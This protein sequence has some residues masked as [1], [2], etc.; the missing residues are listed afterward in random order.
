VAE[1]SVLREFLVEL[2]FRIDEHGMRKFLGETLRVSKGV[3]EIGAA[4]VATAGTVVEMTKKIAERFQSLYFATKFTGASASNIEQLGYALSNVGISSDEAQNS[5]IGLMRRLRDVVGMEGQLNRWGVATRDAMGR[6][7]DNADILVDLIARIRK[8]PFAARRTQMAEMAGIDPDMITKLMSPEAWNKF[9]QKRAEAKRVEQEA[10]VNADKT[11]AASDK[12]GDAFRR[13]G[14]DTGVLEEQIGDKFIG[15]LTTVVLCID[16]LVELFAKLNTQTDGWSTS[17]AALV[18]T[19][20]G[21][22]IAMAGIRAALVAFIG[23]EGLFAMVGAAASAMWAAVFSPVTLVVLA[24]AAVGIAIYELYQHWDWVVKQVKELWATVYPWFKAEWKKLLDYAASWYDTALKWGENIVSGIKKGIESGWD[25]LVLWFKHQVEG[26]FSFLP[27]ALNPLKKA[28]DPGAP[29]PAMGLG[30]SSNIRPG[31]G[32]FDWTPAMAGGA[33][34]ASGAQRVQS[35]L[36]FFEDMGAKP[37]QAAGIVA[38]MQGESSVNL[39]PNALNAIGAYGTMQWLYERKARL[40]ALAKRFGVDPSNVAFQQQ[41][42]KSELQGADP[43]S[44]AAWQ[45]I[46]ASTSGEQAA[47]LWT[48]GVERPE[49]L[50]AEI[51]R[52]LL[53]LP[54]AMAAA[55]NV[56]LGANSAGVGG[57]VSFQQQT[58]INVQGTA[59]ANQ[60]ARAV[61][62]EQGRVNGDVIRHLNPMVQ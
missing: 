15:P 20:G 58:T 21:W 25:D 45:Q 16:H 39:D 32:R 19:F 40:L 36:K 6:A 17:I 7:R 47:A 10:G 43:Q 2:G 34:T 60:T 49:N 46:L 5:V 30:P 52:R 23:G 26:L 28:A 62:N 41:F 48:G 50:N 3:A 12:L 4:A 13:L 31:G 37:F 22:K 8:E 57:G 14:H 56:N 9:L 55:N 11:A 24:I 35:W 51:Q 42:A 61:A 18:I 1:A 29:A 54:N 38:S 27:D 59:D 33:P 53:F 44:A